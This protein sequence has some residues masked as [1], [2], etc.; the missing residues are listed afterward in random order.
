MKRIT[1]EEVDKY[2]KEFCDK[3]NNIIENQVLNET[4][5]RAV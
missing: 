4:E 3:Q 1:D 5:K 2:S